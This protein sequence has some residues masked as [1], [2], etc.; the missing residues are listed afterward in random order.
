MKQ[1][2]QDTKRAQLSLKSPTNKSI[3][4]GEEIVAESINY[5]RLQERGWTRLEAVL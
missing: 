3:L 1:F 5:C 2:I 4:R